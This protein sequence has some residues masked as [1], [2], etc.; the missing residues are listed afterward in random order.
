ML[1]ML[2]ANARNRSGNFRSSGAAA[3]APIIEDAIRTA[4]TAHA[5][6]DVLLSILM[7]DLP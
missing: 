7:S 6:K 3:R 4:A 2:T 5:P 1:L